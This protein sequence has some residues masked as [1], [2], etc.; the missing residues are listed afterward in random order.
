[1]L[2]YVLKSIDKSI[3]ISIE[4]MPANDDNRYIIGIVKAR[5]KESNILNFL[6]PIVR[7]Y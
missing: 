3:D 5:I 7:I 4:G 2:S 1:M 6:L